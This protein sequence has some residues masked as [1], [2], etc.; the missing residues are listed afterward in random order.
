MAM[1]PAPHGR[2]A[3]R[4]RPRAVELSDGSG[5]QFSKHA[6]KRIEQRGLHL[7]DAD[8]TAQRRWQAQAKGSKTVHPPDDLA[9]VVSAEPHGGH[10]HGRGK[11]KEHVF[12]NID[13]VVIAPK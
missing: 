12:T 4:R 8:G 2:L 10:S 13:S 5:S 1:P 7:D 3:C 11:H 9:L 6:A